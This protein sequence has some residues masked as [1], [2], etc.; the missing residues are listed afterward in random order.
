MNGAVVM[1]APLLLVCLDVCRVNKQRMEK[2]NHEKNMRTSLTATKIANLNRLGFEWGKR[3]GD[4]A[5]Q[6]RYQELVEYRQTHGNCDVPTKYIA[7]PALG[8]WVSTQ[9]SQF[10]T[11]PNKHMTQERVNDLNDIGFRWCMMEQDVPSPE[12]QHP[13]ETQPTH[14]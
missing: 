4:E 6:A 9:R 2:K 7:N 5:W 14:E 12:Q 3:K 8:R 11:F 13:N 10:K 1:Y